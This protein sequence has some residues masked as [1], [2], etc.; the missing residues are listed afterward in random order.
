MM[1]GVSPANLH[2]FP[3]GVWIA[4]AL[5]RSA[6]GS[7]RGGGG[8]GRCFRG[9][10]G[11]S[12]VDVVKKVGNPYDLGSLVGGISNPLKKIRISLLGVCFFFYQ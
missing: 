1:A 5:P 7:G 12:V 10:P 3:P 9:G 8:G 6:G 4:T 11:R 2:P